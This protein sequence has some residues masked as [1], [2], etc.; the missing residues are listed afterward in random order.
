MELKVKILREDNTHLQYDAVNE[1]IDKPCFINNT[2]HSLFSDCIVDVNGVK[3]SSSNGF[4]GHKAFIE[5][6]VSYPTEAKETIL[7]TQGYQYEQ[8]PSNHQTILGRRSAK[9]LESKTVYLIGKVAVDFFSCEK[10]LLSGT[11]LQIQFIRA[12]EKFCIL[13]DDAQKSYKP[14]V[15]EANLYVRKLTLSEHEVISQEATLLKT[16][17]EYHFTQVIPRTFVI[18]KGQSSWTQEDIFTK[19]PI[20]RFALALCENGTFVGSPTTNPYQYKKFGLRSITITRNGY[21]M[22][23]SPID[24]S[25]NERIY[26]ITFNSL[27]YGDNSHGISLADF[28]KHY[29]LAFDLTSTQEASYEYIHPELTNGAINLQLEFEAGVPENLSLFLIG[30]RFSTVYIDSARRVSLNNFFHNG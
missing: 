18:G 3:I 19:E 6:E 20:R 4:Y 7:F 21:P 13:S 26:F 15:E 1:N 16:P 28:E 10:A 11:K 23:G 22:L 25:T 8:D 30:E 29:V 24:V 12:P 14:L 9:T 5:T 27:A 2:L 17:A